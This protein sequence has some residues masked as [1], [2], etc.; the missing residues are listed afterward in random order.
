MIF[1]SIGDAEIHNLRHLLDEIFG[2][3]K[4]KLLDRTA[5]CTEAGLRWTLHS[6]DTVTE[7]DPLRC[8]HNAVTRRMWREPESVLAPE[9]RVSV[10]AAIR[11]MTIDAAWQCH[12]EH[13]LG[14]LEPGK[15]ADF[16]ILDEDP[17]AVDPEHIK[18][19][20]IAETWMDGRRVYEERG[21][22]L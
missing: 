15:L 9:E 16:V 14:S 19:I 18:D 11:S 10:E 12:S 5:A 1:V 20:R 22:S 4:A 7:T 8:I 2:P 21:G 17:R 13:E 6:D 3:E